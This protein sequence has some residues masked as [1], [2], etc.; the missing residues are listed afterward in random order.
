MEMILIQNIFDKIIDGMKIDDEIIVF[1]FFNS[2]GFGLFDI[3][4][5]NKHIFIASIL[6]QY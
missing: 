2:N 3:N 6:E 5:I 4:I 1:Y